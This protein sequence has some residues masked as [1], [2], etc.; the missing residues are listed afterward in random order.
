[1]ISGT[2]EDIRTDN[3]T[4]FTLIRSKRKTVSI[5]ITE[6]ATVIVR[7]PGRMPISQIRS[8]VDR[9]ADWIKEHTS[10]I[11]DRNDRIEKYGYISRNELDGLTCL[12]LAT[13]PGKVGFYAKVLGV[14]YG[15]VYIRKQKTLWGSCNSKGDL[16]FNCLLMKAP[17]HVRN[18]V[19]VHELCHRMEMNHS[20]AFWGHV[21]SVIPDYEE[22]R[23]WLREE[24]T[25]LL[26]MS[27]R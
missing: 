18:Y 2:K 8:F 26:R 19:I 5:E 10:K 23:R 21:S 16:S 3:D 15:N 24:G 13:I 9:N 17:E 12:A 4:G 20:K 11:K 6:D 27:V 14:T 7:A 1:M 22:C 25:V